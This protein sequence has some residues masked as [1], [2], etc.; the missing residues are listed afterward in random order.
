M[1]PKWSPKSPNWPPTWSPK[2]MS[3][4]YHQDFAQV[5]LNRLYNDTFQRLKKSPAAGF[6]LLA[7]N[8]HLKKIEDAG[9]NGWTVVDFSVMMV[10]FDLG[11]QQVGRS[12]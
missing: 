9:K 4:F 12:D 11:P 2:L 10:V 8:Y 3:W 1:T 5:L 7:S 6:E